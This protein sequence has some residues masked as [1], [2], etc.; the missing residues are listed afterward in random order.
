MLKIEAFSVISKHLRWFQ[1]LIILKK[2]KKREPYYLIFE[3]LQLLNLNMSFMN[4]RLNNK[5]TSWY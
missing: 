1:L 5:N 2:N 4:I 3:Y